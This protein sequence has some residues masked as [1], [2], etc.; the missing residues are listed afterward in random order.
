MLKVDA[1]EEF[2]KMGLPPGENSGNPV[3]GLSAVHAYSSGRLTQCWSESLVGLTL[4]S[5]NF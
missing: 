4:D 1:G 5:V 3:L 2:H